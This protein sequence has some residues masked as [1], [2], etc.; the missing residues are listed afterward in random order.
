LGRPLVES[1]RD[2]LTR[3]Y[4]EDIYN[5]ILAASRGEEGGDQ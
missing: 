3:A 5:R 4:G 1:L 2:A